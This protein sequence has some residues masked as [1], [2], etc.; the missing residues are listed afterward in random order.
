MPNFE[1]Q[2]LIHA[3][4][5][6]EKIRFKEFG[7]EDAHYCKLYDALNEA[8]LS[9]EPDFKSLFQDRD[10]MR[11]YSY[12][13]GYLLNTLMD[14]MR[15]QRQRG[16]MDKLPHHQVADVLQDAEFLHEKTFV[17]LCWKRLEKAEKIARKHELHEEL[18]K[19][20]RF[21]LKI[22]IANQE[23]HYPEISQAV[24]LE[25]VTLAKIILNKSHF[26]ALK[27]SLLVLVRVAP[28]ARDADQKIQLASLLD[29]DLLSEVGQA[30]SFDA[31]LNFHFCHILN[32]Q[33]RKDQPA[34]LAHSQDVYQLWQDF[35]QFQ[36][37]RPTDFK[38]AL[39]NYLI[40]CCAADHYEDFA[41]A[42]TQLEAEPFRSLEQKAEVKQIS[43]YVR[44][45]Y[46]MRK[47]LWED[48]V[49]IEE[50]FE[51][52]LASFVHKLNPAR[53]LAF[54]I[55]FARL[56]HIMGNLDKAILWNERIVVLRGDHVRRDICRHALLY[57]LV[58]FY[59]T[60]DI[61]KLENRYRVVMRSLDKE[62]LVL[63][64]ERLVVALLKRLPNIP[65]LPELVGEL[66]LFLPELERL[67]S[68]PQEA[69]AQ[70]FEFLKNWA[71]SKVEGLDL[72]AFL[73]QRQA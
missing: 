32:G 1:L 31:R 57:S 41:A 68:H 26:Q 69:K 38:N 55:S 67:S 45:H 21:K 11:K 19:I 33:I 15:S 14:A 72:K 63:E 30:L 42:V 46:F 7:D 2:N 49:E 20:L 28:E 73:S 6:G 43:L 34:M 39:N 36:V 54:Y 56:N 58:L 70:G 9:T 10:F 37:S 3:L 60:G 12:N 62:E 40:I 64:Y 5:K 4:D 24:S 66:S 61:D 44:L 59:E 29:D 53:E 23:R 27:N 8:T 52:N 25:V 13:K 35:P 71:S 48:A 50:D 51:L 22:L 17:D 16:G 18:I 65:S 47:Y